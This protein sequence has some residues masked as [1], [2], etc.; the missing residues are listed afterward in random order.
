MLLDLLKL[1]TWGGILTGISLLSLRGVKKGDPASVRW[2]IALLLLLQGGAAAALIYGIHTYQRNAHLLDFRQ[3]HT[4]SAG[5][6]FVRLPA[7]E[8]QMGCRG[9]KGHEC[10]RKDAPEHTAVIDKPFFIGRYEVTQAQWKAVMGKA[11]GDFLRQRDANRPVDDATFAD[12]EAFVARLNERENT[13]RYRLPSEAEW[14]YAASAG[15]EEFLSF[16]YDNFGDYLWHEENAEGEAHPV[17]EKYP[18]SWGLFDMA[19]N[20]LEWVSGTYTPYPGAAFPTPEESRERVMRGGSWYRP[21]L[22]VGF[23]YNEEWLRARDPENFPAHDRG[24]RV[25]FTAD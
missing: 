14:E 17:G 5:M 1:V 12:A 21:L 23:R 2:H 13:H 16:P 8:F 22:P 19:G 20:V 24:F 7:G 18:N 3:T 15:G 9:A 10:W 6:E 4:N 25:V 11:R